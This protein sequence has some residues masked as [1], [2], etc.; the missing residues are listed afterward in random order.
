MQNLRS[1]RFEMS[2]VELYEPEVDWDNT[3]FSSMERHRV[4]G[5]QQ[6]FVI[7]FGVQSMGIS[8]TRLG[9]TTKNLL[10]GLTSGQ[11]LRLDKRILDPSRP[12]GTQMSQQEKEAGVMPYFSTIGV[13]PKFV[14]THTNNIKNVRAITTTTT[15]ME[16]TSLVF[17]FG[18]DNFFTRIAPSKTFDMLNAGFN[19]VFLIMSI[20]ALLIL[21]PTA[22]CLA[23]RGLVRSHWK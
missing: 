10:I 9:I 6:S 19:Y 1:H 13:N 20:V 14:I 12:L 15:T 16:S 23:R 8:T 7:P 17:V 22:R 4:I 11:V 5:E 3:T 21:T 18:L 2:V